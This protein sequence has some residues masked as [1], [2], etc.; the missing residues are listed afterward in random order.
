MM[1][2]LFAGPNLDFWLHGHTCMANADWM[3]RGIY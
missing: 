1:N 2:Q 3:G